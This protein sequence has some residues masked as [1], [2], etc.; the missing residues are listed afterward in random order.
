MPSSKRQRQ[1]QRLA[2]GPCVHGACLAI[3]MAGMVPAAEA[4]PATYVNSFTVSKSQAECLRDTR[5]ALLKVGM[6]SDGI[7][8]TS[9]TDKNGQS[10]QDGWTADHPSE[11]VSVS[12]ECD[13]RNGMGAF[14]VSG[15]N[16]DTT[17]RIYRTLWNLWMR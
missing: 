15:A 9:Y 16:H 8:Q 13:A 10:I 2:D 3:L 6:G 12:F 11:N 7:A 1:R 4:G 14:A 17:Y 5:E